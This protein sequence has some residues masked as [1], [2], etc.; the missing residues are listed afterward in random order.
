MNR[1]DIVCCDQT[2]CGSLFHSLGEAIA[3]PL[4]PMAFLG[5]TEET[6]SRFLRVRLLVLI[7]DEKYAGWE[8]LM[9][10]NVMRLYL[11]KMRYEMGNVC[12][13]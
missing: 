3:K 8:Y 2:D 11:N 6:D 10:L 4:L 13:L 7:K 9:T 5:Q 12:S 1:P